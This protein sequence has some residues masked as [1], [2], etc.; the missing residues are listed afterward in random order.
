M[1]RRFKYL[2]E[3]AQALNSNN[4]DFS[5]SLSTGKTYQAVKVGYAQAKAL[6]LVYPVFPEGSRFRDRQAG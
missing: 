3:P 4:M 2:G 6:K 1:W 5:T